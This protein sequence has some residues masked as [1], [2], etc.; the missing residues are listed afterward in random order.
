MC[1]I[2]IMDLEQKI[3]KNNKVIYKDVEIDVGITE[4]SEIV[5][6][7]NPDNGIEY[8]LYHHNKQGVSGSQSY[9]NITSFSDKGKSLGHKIIQNKIYKKVSVVSLKNGK[10]FLDIAH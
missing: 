10:I 2:V 4:A 1:F 5:E 7:R 3:N 8:V 9:E 6:S